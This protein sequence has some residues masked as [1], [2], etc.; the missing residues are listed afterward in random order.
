MGRFGR[1][2]AI[3][4]DRDN[5][6]AGGQVLPGRTLDEQQPIFAGAALR[7]Q[8]VCEEGVSPGRTESDRDSQDE[9]GRCEEHGQTEHPIGQLVTG[10]EQFALHLFS[11]CGSRLASG[12]FG[13]CV[14]SSM[15]R[16]SFVL[17][18]RSTKPAITSPVTVPPLVKVKIR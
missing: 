13:F 2:R 17:S 18:A 7:S 1:R 4:G 16:W 6:P 11:A 10:T 3:R 8:E 14:R 15:A 5:I 9:D 12:L